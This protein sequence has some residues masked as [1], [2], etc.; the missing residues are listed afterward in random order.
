MK[1]SLSLFFILYE[2][3]IRETGGLMVKTLQ[4]KCIRYFRFSVFFFNYPINQYR[5]RNIILGE[6]GLN[7]QT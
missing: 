3:N 4:L 7:V 1:Y 2:Q 5:G 6:G